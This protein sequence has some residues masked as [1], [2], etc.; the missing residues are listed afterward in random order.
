MELSHYEHHDAMDVYCISRWDVTGRHKIARD[1]HEESITSGLKLKPFCRPKYFPKFLALPTEILLKIVADYDLIHRDLAAL[2]LTCRTMQ[3]LAQAPLYRRIHLRIH[4]PWAQRARRLR[5]R[6]PIKDVWDAQFKERPELSKMVK[7]LV[8]SGRGDTTFDASEIFRLFPNTEDVHLIPTFR[9]IEPAKAFRSTTIRSLKISSDE[10]LDWEQWYKL[11]LLPSLEHL[12]LRGTPSL[13]TGAR[14]SPVQKLEFDRSVGSSNVSSF[15]VG[16]WEPFDGFRDLLAL[17]RALKEFSACYTTIEDGDECQML[18]IAHVLG[19]QMADLQYI[20]LAFDSRKE[21][22]IHKRHEY[23]DFR[24]FPNLR[25]LEIDEQLLMPHSRITGPDGHDPIES[26]PFQLKVLKI[27]MSCSWNGPLNPYPGLVD[28]EDWIQQVALQKQAG[29]LSIESLSIRPHTRDFAT[30][31][32]STAAG[33]Y[34]GEDRSYYTPTP[35]LLVPWK[36]DSKREWDQFEMFE[37]A[38]IKLEVYNVV[39]E[40]SVRAN[41]CEYRK[42]Y[43]F[44]EPWK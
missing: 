31:F 17:P 30:M 15:H 34:H 6:P 7:K 14:L 32:R 12:S 13:A 2:S 4:Q 22:K 43:E 9:L 26:I 27:V 10:K 24:K 28:R 40:S 35:Y 36:E 42:I 18:D 29:N 23:A 20:S 33:W 44:Y 1:W 19:P 41:P 3:L 38:N 5:S 11:F 8:L 25:H 21:I 37:K 39:P 16:C